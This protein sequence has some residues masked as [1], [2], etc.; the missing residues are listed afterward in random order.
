MWRWSGTSG[1]SRWASS[2]R[3]TGWH[4][5][6][7]SSSTWV[8]TAPEDRGGGS[9][10]RQT[11]RE[12]ELAV[13]VAA[14]ERGVVAVRESEA[15]LRQSLADGAKHARLADPGLTGEQYGLSVFERLAN[16]IDERHLR[17]GQPQLVVG[18]FLREGCAR[19]AEVHQ[20]RRRHDSPPFLPMALF[21]SALGGSK[22]ECGGMSSPC[23]SSRRSRRRLPLATA[24]TGCNSTRRISNSA[25]GFS[26]KSTRQRQSVTSRPARCTPSSS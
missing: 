3:K 20:V 2:S 12:A 13:E 15:S 21:S 10:G 9:R 18:D 17:R 23:L 7:P 16:F 11:E 19:E 4:R 24:S 6:R 26:L 14:T 1:C 5:S 25:Q 8:L 22:T